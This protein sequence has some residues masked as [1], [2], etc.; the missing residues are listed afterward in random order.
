MDE[1]QLELKG[2][3]GN[4]YT[5]FPR[6]K[7]G[8]ASKGAGIYIFTNENDAIEDIQFLS[9]EDEINATLQR[10]KDDGA[11]YFY[12]TDNLDR[13]QSDANIDDIKEGEDYRKK[14]D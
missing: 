9:D 5:F 6:Y 1:K 4:K 7:I 12:F 11:V 8:E 14:S 10:M 3:S 13:L 2:K